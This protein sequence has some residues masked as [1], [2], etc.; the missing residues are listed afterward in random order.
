[1]NTPDTKVIRTLRPQRSD[2]AIKKAAAQA[3]VNEVVLWHR[4]CGDKRLDAALFD[5]VIRDLESLPTTH[6]I[7]TLCR[8]LESRGYFPD[9]GLYRALESWPTEIANAHIAAVKGWVVSEGLKPQF[10]VGDPVRV[11]SP[12]RGYMDGVIS[13]VRGELAEYAVEC[14]ELSA[15]KGLSSD[16]RFIFAAEAVT[17]RRI[18]IESSPKP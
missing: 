9:D 1:M 15:G 17:A 2:P 14:P 12:S 8:S 10:D 18:V 5:D 7:Y 11:W 16:V 3:C 13:E 4:D 6:D